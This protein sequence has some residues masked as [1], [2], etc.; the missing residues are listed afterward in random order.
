MLNFFWDIIGKFGGTQMGIILII[1][2]FHHK[3]W[4]QLRL[5][6][7]TIM[8]SYGLNINRNKIKNIALVTL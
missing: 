2:E 8:G 4:N 1:F 6:K 7:R 3:H 5:K